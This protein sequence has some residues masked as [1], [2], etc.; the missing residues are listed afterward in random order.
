MKYLALLFVFAL[1]LQRSYQQHNHNQLKNLR[2][3]A[4]WKELEFSFPSQEV[5]NAAIA[6]GDYIRGNALPIDVDVDYK[7]QGNSRV[8]VT[9]PRFVTGIPI[10]LGVVSTNGANGGPLL[11]AYPEY[12][13]Q[14]RA[15]Q[16]C[17]GITSVFR[18]AVDDCRRLW[19]IDTGRVGDVQS[20]QPQILIFNLDTDELIHR[21]KV[22][23]D[24]I[25]PGVTLYI[26]PVLDVRDPPPS[27]QC[28]N[29]MAYIADVNGFSLLVFDLRN[30]RSW[31]VQ[32]KL[33][34]SCPA[35][36][37]YTIL[38]DSFDLMDGVFGLALSPRTTYSGPGGSGRTLYFHSLASITENAVRLNVL[39][40]S[41]LWT[42]NADS[43][44]RSF[45]E[46]GTRD[47]QATAQAMDSNGNLFFGLVNPIAVAC[48]D[49]NAPYAR[50]N[51]RIVAQNDQT[52]QFSSGLKVVR[53]K[54]GKEELWVLSC[55]FQK[56]MNE[57]LNNQVVNFRIQAIHID[58]LL[59][60]NRCISG[61]LST[62]HFS[63]SYPS[64]G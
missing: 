22:P 26:T 37:T 30:N 21:Y 35:Y 20:C 13:W 39:D 51:M 64:Y 52:L 31:R 16:N 45:V 15:G 57:K 11:E 44:P 42:A 56:Y 5:R 3:V 17:D 58:D 10:T 14:S 18:V 46:I 2:L 25:K 54:K 29:T 4:E 50:E 7:S 40:N 43:T 59:N 32:N 24:Q 23:Y 53:N 8:F 60:G 63:S 12:S 38:G 27:G 48:W 61:G 9:V 62:H 34:Y 1:T 19:V 47:T 41:T 49:S 28:A 6:S 36:G 33:F 55:S